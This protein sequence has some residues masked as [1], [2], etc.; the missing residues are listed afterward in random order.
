VQI[1]GEIKGENSM[2]FCKVS[3]FLALFAV[4]CLPAVAQTRMSLDIPF[5]FVVAGKSLPAGHYLVLPAFKSDNTAWSI[6]SDHNDCATVLT[7][8]AASP[9]EHRRTMVFLM[10]SQGYALI[11]FWPEGDLGRNLTMPKV[12]QTLVAERDRYLEI[13]AK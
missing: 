2:K 4:A 12:K 5:N 9:A 11:Q 1:I 10:T 8:T 7:Q 6:C 3:L 13:A